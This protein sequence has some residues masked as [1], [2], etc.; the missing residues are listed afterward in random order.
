MRGSD[1]RVGHFVGSLAVLSCITSSS[2]W[3]IC[4]HR[5]WRKEEDVVSCGDFWWWFMPTLRASCI[6]WLI[7]QTRFSICLG[8]AKTGS[9]CRLICLTYDQMMLS[10]RLPDWVY[11]SILL[12]REKSFREAMDWL[13]ESLVGLCRNFG[14]IWTSVWSA[15][16]WTGS[17]FVFFC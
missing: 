5:N 12:S 9:C 11:V 1:W 15:L 13:C 4:V 6:C 8:S 14:A 17:L 10:E 16:M 7:F 2:F 3:D